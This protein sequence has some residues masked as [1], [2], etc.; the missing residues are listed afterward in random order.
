MLVDAEAVEAHALGVLQLVEVL[1]VEAAALLGIEEAVG[2]VDPHRPVPR[3]EV[4]GQK[5][6]RHEV[7]EAD[8]HVGPRCQRMIARPKRRPP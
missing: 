6:I 5:T 2:H 8:F 1:V 7:E 3:F 4:V